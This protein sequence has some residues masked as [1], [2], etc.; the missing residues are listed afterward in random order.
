MGNELAEIEHGMKSLA[1]E[2][3]PD[4]RKNNDVI[5]IGIKLFLHLLALREIFLPDIAR[6]AE[7]TFR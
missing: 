3:F 7:G 5:P 4:E 2:V 6:Y 1:T